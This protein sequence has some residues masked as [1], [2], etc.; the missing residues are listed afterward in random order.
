MK[1]ETL[2]KIL[3]KCFEKKKSIILIGDYGIG[4]SR[5]VY[6][7][8]KEKAKELNKELVIWH[9]L[10]EHE[11]MRL[12]NSN[13]DNYFILVDIKLQSIGD[14]SK[15]MGI[16]IIING[17]HEQ[18]IVW[19]PP[20]FIKVLCKENAYGILFLD[21]INMALPSLQSL[22]FEIFLQRKIGE[23]KLSDNVLVCGAGNSLDVNVAANPIPKPLLNRVLLIKDI[24]IDVDEWIN[25]AFKNDIDNRIIAFVKC[26]RELKKDSDEEL[27]QSTRPRSY[28]ILS[29]M[30]KNEEDIE[31]IEAFAYALLEKSTA[32]KFVAFVKNLQKFVNYK[33]YIENYD[34]FEKLSL[35]EKYALIT[36]IAKNIKEI[37]DEKIVEFITDLVNDITELG[38]LLLNFIKREDTKKFDEIF[39]KLDESV[40]NRLFD[41][42]I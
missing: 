23:W 6:E 40:I 27:E 38:A 22:C 17:E 25:W 3:H 13:L 20:L 7:F 36:V 21:E 5:I 42:I 37:E 41:L 2:K 29:D 30:I 4:K 35:E 15:I 24:E 12:I 33:K 16:P 1:V 28:E 19:E 18:K 11:K 31:L 34:E 39:E 8:A 32:S 10:N 26:F 14:P 9:E